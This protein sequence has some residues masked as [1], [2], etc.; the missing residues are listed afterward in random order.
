MDTLAH[1][2]ESFEQLQ[3]ID[4]AKRKFCDAIRDRIQIA[5]D[6]ASICACRL[7]RHNTATGERVKDNFALAAVNPNMLADYVPSLSR[8][9]FVLHIHRSVWFGRN[10]S[11]D[12]LDTRSI[13]Y[14]KW[15]R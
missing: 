15:P 10:L 13:Y 3:S 9:I 14:N 6:C 2:L 1:A 11:V 12:M 4:T 7:N 5:H 8:P